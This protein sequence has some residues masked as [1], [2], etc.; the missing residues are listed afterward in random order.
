MW[1]AYMRRAGCGRSIGGVVSVTVCN[2]FRTIMTVRTDPHRPP[3]ETHETSTEKGVCTIVRALVRSHALCTCP[4]GY[5]PFFERHVRHL[6][7]P[8]SEGVQP[9]LFFCVVLLYK[10]NVLSKRSLRFEF[11]GHSWVP[12]VKDIDEPAH[13]SV[14]E[15]QT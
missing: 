2:A 5:A 7:N 13:G 9:S 15:T 4:C 11:L 6:I 14:R 12:F 3:N 1:C 10:R 8:T